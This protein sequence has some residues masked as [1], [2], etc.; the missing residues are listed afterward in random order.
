MSIEKRARDTESYPQTYA[1]EVETAYA[2]N[3]E[4]GLGMIR[5]FGNGNTYQ[6]VRAATTLT[7]NQVLYAASA[8]GAVATGEAVLVA[9]AAGSNVLYPT[10]ITAVGAYGPGDWVHIYSGDGIGQLREI[11]HVAPYS[12]TGKIIIK[13]TWTTAL[14]IVTTTSDYQIIRPFLM[15][16]SSTNK[17]CVQGVTQ[18]AVTDQYYFWMLKSGIGQVICDTGS[19]AMVAGEPFVASNDGAGMVEGLD[20]SNT[21][22]L[23]ADGRRIIGYAVSDGAGTDNFVPAMITLGN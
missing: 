21:N 14:V 17:C 9:S 18:I 19:Q 23:A 16:P 12:T 13:G 22:T 1:T 4:G 11:D 7:A 15:T 3:V 5:K 20:L 6:W 2:T 10:T 8:F